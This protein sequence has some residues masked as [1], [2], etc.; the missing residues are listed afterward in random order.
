[1]LLACLGVAALRRD[2]TKPALERRLMGQP[3]AWERHASGLF[4]CAGS[5]ALFSSTEPPTDF[6]CVLNKY[7]FAPM[8]LTSKWDIG[9]GAAK[10]GFA[11]FSHR[12]KIRAGAERLPQLCQSMPDRNSHDKVG[13]PR[14]DAGQEAQ[15]DDA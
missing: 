10:G 8:L 13:K 4:L 6:S 5:V 7:C 3:E 1:A 14:G 9:A 11:E 12:A 2:L 15:N